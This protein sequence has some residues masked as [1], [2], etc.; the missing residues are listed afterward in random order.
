MPSK[1]VKYSEACALKV[2]PEPYYENLR[3]TLPLSQGHEE[4]LVALWQRFSQEEPSA[5]CNEIVS[6]KRQTAVI[7]LTMLRSR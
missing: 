7:R 3:P 1:E 6:P 5:M 2:S 4:M